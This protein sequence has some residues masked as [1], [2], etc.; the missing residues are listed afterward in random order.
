MSEEIVRNAVFQAID[1][2]NRLLPKR[3]HLIKS[4]ETVLF[5]EQSGL[6]SMNLINFLVAFE[7][8]LE[9]HTG[10]SLSLTTDPIL[11]QDGKPLANVKTLI[12]YVSSELQN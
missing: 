8:S 2:V 7:D 11:L 6:D 4:E 9:E 10:H 1:C 12:H 5:G 3:R